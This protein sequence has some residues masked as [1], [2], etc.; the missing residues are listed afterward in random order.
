MADAFGQDNI[1]YPPKKSNASIRGEHLKRAP[2]TLQT[3]AIDYLLLKRIVKVAV[4]KSSNSS[5]V[6]KFLV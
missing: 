5:N 2:K 6:R 3:K 4:M 1:S